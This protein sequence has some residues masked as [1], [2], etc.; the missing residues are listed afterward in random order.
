MS[1]RSRN[2]RTVSKLLAL[3]T[4]TMVGTMV[5]AGMTRYVTFVQAG[6]SPTIS[7]P[8]SVVVYFASA[9]VSNQSIG[10]V[11]ATAGRKLRTL[12]RTTGVS[13]YAQ[14]NPMVT[15]PRKPSLENPLF[16]I[17]A[18]KWLF[19]GASVTSGQVLVQYF[20]E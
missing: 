8:S 16:T 10:G 2:I 20:E 12:I 11:R 1:Y 15:I 9:G 14:G 7:R 5:P 6:P 19:T 3:N 13:G 17:A 4:A 18:S